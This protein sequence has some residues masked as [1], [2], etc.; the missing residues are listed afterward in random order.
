MSN[1]H[2]FCQHCGGELRQDGV[3]GYRYVGETAEGKKPTAEVVGAL[4]D[5]A[6]AIREHALATCNYLDAS[7]PMQA[8]LMKR[9]GWKP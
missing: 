6:A 7:G 9:R 1:E 4:R 2:R 3:R 5:I 8:E